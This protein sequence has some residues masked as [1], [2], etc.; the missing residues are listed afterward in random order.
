M[1]DHNIL[2]LIIYLTIKNAIKCIF[3]LTIMTNSPRPHMKGWH[4]A[5]PS[6][7]SYLTPFLT[8]SDTSNVIRF[9][10]FTISSIG[11]Q[12]TPHFRTMTHLSAK[13]AT[14]CSRM[15]R[16]WD[17]TTKPITSF[18]IQKRQPVQHQENQNLQIRF[19]L[20]LLDSTYFFVML[21]HSLWPL[22]SWPGC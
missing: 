15:R 5:V 20:N 9:L 6:A 7:G 16:T 17:T 1:I 10:K 13:T 12:T 19:F 2:L 4:T 8:E 18:P 21:D 22:F 11:V 14:R 3:F